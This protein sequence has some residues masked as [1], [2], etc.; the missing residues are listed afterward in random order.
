L[1]D[2]YIS[3]HLGLP[4]KEGYARAEAAA[5]KALQLDD[6]LAEAHTSLAITR[7]YAWDWPDAEREYRRAIELDPNCAAA[8]EW[9]AFYLETEGRTDEGF[10]EIHRAMALNPLSLT[11]N[12]GL[13]RMYYS[14]RQYDQ[15]IAQYKKTLELDPNVL[16][17]RLRL[18][19]A[20]S[21]KG[22][23]DES[24]AEF[25][26]AREIL[27]APSGLHGVDVVSIRLAQAQAFLGRRDEA[28]KVIDQWKRL[29]P[30]GAISLQEVAIIYVGLGE[31]DEAFALME[32][33]YAER[34]FH[35][36]SL[37]SDPRFDP[38][39]SD[40]RYVGLLRRVGF[41]M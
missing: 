18:G 40:P 39:R 14:N 28:K 32:R 33:A 29:P 34:D 15:A 4:P 22:L 11:I 36:A 38:I 21:Q 37:K 23:A 41:P 25:R 17:V 1:A 20:L 30:A 10:A 16:W 13:G 31:K 2:C 27:P 24:L 5:L 19:Q 12:T 7:F 6:T 26:K 35:L 3:G 9:Y 8:H